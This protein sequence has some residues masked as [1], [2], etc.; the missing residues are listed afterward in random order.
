MNLSYILRFRGVH[1]GD[2]GR[3]ILSEPVSVS[4]E[5]LLP[6]FPFFFPCPS[7]FVVVCV[8]LG[9]GS[10]DETWNNQW[11]NLGVIG[12]NSVVAK[13]AGVTYPRISAP[14]KGDSVAVPPLNKGSRDFDRSM[15]LTSLG[16]LSISLSTN[17]SVGRTFQNVANHDV[18]IFSCL[19]DLPAFGNP[20]LSFY[21]HQALVPSDQTGLTVVPW[22]RPRLSSEQSLPR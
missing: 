20:G 6:G 1:G 12:G 19:N 18:T 11:G 10:S 7:L 2:V 8:A 4:D 13:I 5:S 9:V 15:F 17:S 3:G 21:F 22:E 16:F 14:L